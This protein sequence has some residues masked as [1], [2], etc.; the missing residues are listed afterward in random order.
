M[1]FAVTSVG[2]YVSIVAFAEPGVVPEASEFSR[3]VTRARAFVAEHHPALA[4]ALRG[5]KVHKDL[6]VNYQPSEGVEILPS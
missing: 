1:H 5:V 2:E 3:A 4:D 6:T